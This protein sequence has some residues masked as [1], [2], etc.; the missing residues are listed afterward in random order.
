MYVH[1]IL[2]VYLEL[3]ITEY[4]VRTHSTYLSVSMPNAQTQASVLQGCVS[5]EY[6]KMNNKL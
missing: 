3:A 5:A 4:A 1:K 6:A 2:N